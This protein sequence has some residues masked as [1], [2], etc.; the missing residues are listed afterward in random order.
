[1]SGLPDITAGMAKPTVGRQD[2]GKRHH[3]LMRDGLRPDT[4]TAMTGM[5]IRKVT[6]D[7]FVVSGADYLTARGHGVMFGDCGDSHGASLK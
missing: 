2:G 3:A 7:R 5:S 1:M 4:H 6:G